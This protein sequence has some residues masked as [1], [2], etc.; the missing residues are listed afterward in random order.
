MYYQNHDLEDLLKDPSFRKYVLKPTPGLELFWKNWLIQNPEKAAEVKYARLILKSM[1]FNEKELSDR[2]KAVLFQK[3]LKTNSLEDTKHS[4]KPVVKP[5]HRAVSNQ[6]GE[7]NHITKY[8][9]RYAAILGGAIVF[10][11]SIEFFAGDTEDK[12]EVQL[13]KKINKQGQKSTI[14]LP[15]GTVVSLNSSSTIIYPAE[16]ITDV[17]EISLN[18]EAFF[19]VARDSKPFVVKMNN[20]EAKVLG[21]SFNARSFASSDDY[22]ISLVTG[23]V[24]VYPTDNYD[25]HIILNPGE[26]ISLNVDDKTLL[27]SNFSYDEEIL[28]KDGILYFKNTPFRE[29][30]ARMEQWYGVNFIVDKWPDEEYKVT[31][32][33][34]NESLESVLSSMSFTLRFQYKIKG[35]KVDIHL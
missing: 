12:P 31:G 7:K 21:T 19:K 14:F 20:L 29:A 24:E 28:W 30:I 5:I 22:S 3:I 11:L 26:K 13:V 8:F 16:F 1:K 35:N 34:D 9:L 4:K 17:R 10:A 15:D 18:G 6:K 2:E 32:K 25:K 33:F 23:Q 27:K